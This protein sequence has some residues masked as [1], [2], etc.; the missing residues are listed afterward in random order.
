MLKEIKQSQ[1]GKVQLQ[2]SIKMLNQWN[3]NQSNINLFRAPAPAL[4]KIKCW[5]RIIQQINIAGTNS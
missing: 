4:R 3:L 1:A 5:F 2:L